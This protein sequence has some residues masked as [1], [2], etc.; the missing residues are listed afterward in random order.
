MVLSRFHPFEITIDVVKDYFCFLLIK[1]S[2]NPCH[3]IIVRFAIVAA[4]YAMT[5]W[6]N[7]KWY[8]ARTI[9]RRN[10]NPMI[11]RK[12]MPQT[13]RSIAYCAAI[14]EILKTTLPIFCCKLIGEIELSSIALM[15]VDLYLI[16]MILLPASSNS[17]VNMRSRFASS[18]TIFSHSIKMYVVIISSLCS[19]SL[20]IISV[21]SSTIRRAT[22]FAISAQSYLAFL[23]FPSFKKFIGSR[24]PFIT[25]AA[26][27]KFRSRIVEHSTF[28]SCCLPDVMSASG[29]KNHR[30]G[31]TLADFFIIPYWERI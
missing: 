16:W 10:R 3:W 2:I 20:S 14:I 21:I 22:N 31:A 24:L 9:W 13:T 6:N 29:G 15:K 25:F 26:L 8:C 19:L 1:D 18:A 4:I 30:S 11:H 28:T 7:V 17:T 5:K 23:V 27:S 12:S